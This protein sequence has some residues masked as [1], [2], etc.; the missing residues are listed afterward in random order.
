MH[1]TTLIPITELNPHL[2]CVLC[3]GYLVDATTIVECL[4]SFCKTCIVSYLKSCEYCPIC[5]VMVHK[6]KPH[7]NLRPD[8]QL[9]ALVYKLVPGLFKDEM[10]RRREFYADHPEAGPSTRAVEERGEVEEEYVI[11][12]L[13]EKISLSL[14]Y[15]SHSNETNP[16]QEHIDATVRQHWSTRYLLC[17]A[18]FLVCHLKKFIRMKFQL[19]KKSKVDIMH[20]KATEE[21]LKDDY[22]LMD[23]CYIYAWR[24]DN[25]LRLFYSIE[26]IKDAPPT[27][28]M[29]LTHQPILSEKV[30]SEKAHVKASETSDSSAIDKDIIIVDEAPSCSD[31]KTDNMDKIN[32][33]ESVAG[34]SNDINTRTQNGNMEQAEN[35]TEEADTMIQNKV[36]DTPCVDT[37]DNSNKIASS[38]ENTTND[39][40]LPVSDNSGSV[41]QSGEPQITVTDKHNGPDITVEKSHSISITNE[42]HTEST[43]YADSHMDTNLN[44]ESQN[45]IDGDHEEDVDINIMDNDDDDYCPETPQSPDPPQ[46]PMFTDPSGSNDETDDTDHP[47]QINLDSIDSATDNNDSNGMDCTPDSQVSETL[48]E[49]ELTD[50]NVTHAN[51]D[52][53]QNNTHEPAQSGHESTHIG[54]THVPHV[55]NGDTAYSYDPTQVPGVQRSVPA[56]HQMDMGLQAGPI[57]SPILENILPPPNPMLAHPVITQPSHIMENALPPL[58]ALMQHNTQTMNSIMENTNRLV[59]TYGVNPLIDIMD[60]NTNAIN[61]LLHNPSAMNLFDQNTMNRIHGDLHTQINPMIQNHP[62]AMNNILEN[63]KNIRFPGLHNGLPTTIPPEQMHNIGAPQNQGMHPMVSMKNTKLA[64]PMEVQ[65][66]I[67]PSTMNN[68]GIIPNPTPPTVLKPTKDQTSATMDLIPK[69]LTPSAINNQTLPLVNSNG[70]TLND[71]MMNNHVQ[72]TNHTALKEM[73]YNTPIPASMNLSTTTS[74]PDTSIASTTESVNS[75][76]DT[77]KDSETE[78]A[79]SSSTESSPDNNNKGSTSPGFTSLEK[80][81]GCAANAANVGVAKAKAKS[82]QTGRSGYQNRKRRS[83]NKAAGVKQPTTKVTA[84]QL[85]AG[86]S[87]KKTDGLN[88]PQRQVEE[89]P[90]VKQE[91]EADSRPQL[92]NNKTPEPTNALNLTIKTSP[93]DLTGD[94]ER[95]SETDIE[96]INEESM[97]PTIPILSMPQFTSGSFTS[98]PSPITSSS[99]IGGRVVSSQHPGARKTP[100]LTN[101]RKSRTR[102]PPK[103]T[104]YSKAAQKEQTKLI[105]PQSLQSMTPLLDSIKTSG[106]SVQ[107]LSIPKQQL[108]NGGQISLPVSLTGT[109]GKTSA[110]LLST[111]PT[112]SG[113]NMAIKQM[114]QM[115]ILTPTENPYWLVTSGISMAHRTPVTSQNGLNTSRNTIRPP[116][117]QANKRTQP[118]INRI[119]AH[120]NRPSA[121]KE[122]PMASDYI[123]SAIQ[124]LNSTLKP[125]DGVKYSENNT[126]KPNGLI[127]SKPQYGI[128]GKTLTNAL[129]KVNGHM[130]S[131][132]AKYQKLNGMMSVITKT[133]PTILNNVNNSTTDSSR[134]MNNKRTRSDV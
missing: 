41:Y 120:L 29:K 46:S 89:D 71:T 80:C 134:N 55:I 68:L 82:A 38:K 116:P 26:D 104:I 88:I 2:M 110:Y 106:A 129:P 52:I 64:N 40:E 49:S 79:Q 108:M 83:K 85:I 12:T 95:V 54:A 118:L 107:L 128:M 67:P 36:P 94:K 45:N 19:P 124:K 125:Q 62:Q 20:Y 105:T 102:T 22:T 93:K 60:S 10:K 5:D 57:H 77:G 98:N 75:T 112:S 127:Q 14:E 73:D 39:T 21:V 133:T 96:N 11:H 114:L 69:T 58:N 33:E 86:V 117:N 23:I 51:Q 16:V 121:P 27:K 123:K 37:I 28:K 25:P 122:T 111:P 61:M 100:L 92:G 76:P 99:Y 1:R 81:D 48:P 130:S 15:F 63:M 72:D 44:P 65:H 13:D 6:T 24:R 7:V 31:T 70:T 3:G 91:S 18:G 32:T 47:L 42:T 90:V 78:Q 87:L 97:S 103:N 8:K 4:H 84:S 35:V 34:T 50:C 126:T 101:S 30:P 113:G 131:R 74:V 43:D 132:P 17:P 66:T 53:S 59:S 115:P 56:P 119:P 109:K 9:Q